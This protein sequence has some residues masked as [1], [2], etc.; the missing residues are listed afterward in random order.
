MHLLGVRENDG[1]LESA[2]EFTYRVGWEHIKTAVYEVYDAIENP[3]VLVRFEHVDISGKEEI[4][5]L[6]EELNMTIRGY[7]ALIKNRVMITFHNQVKTVTVV[8]PTDDSEYKEADYE[9]FNHSM[10]EFMSSIE[11]NMFENV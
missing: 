1:W 3:E 9:K 10:C 4:K 5:D 8:M 11:I 2:W 7:C 6:E